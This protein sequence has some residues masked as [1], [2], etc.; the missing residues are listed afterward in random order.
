[1]QHHQKSIPL[2]QDEPLSRLDW[3]Y[4]RWGGVSAVVLTKLW[5]RIHRRPSYKIELDRPVDPA[6]PT[7]FA[8]NHQVS[9][10]PPAIFSAFSFRDLVR[11]SPVKFMTYHKYYNS[12]FKF[13]LYTTGCYPSHG[14]GLTGVKGAVYFARHGYCSFIF[15]EGKRMRNGERGKA[16]EGISRIL[17]EIPEA[18][19][20]LVRINWEPRRRFLSRPGIQVTIS[21]APKNLNRNDPDA[22]MD[23]IYKLK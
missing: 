16:Y 6:H 21:D 9:L 19:L 20:L 17:E 13:P 2:I 23:E 10:D 8:S 15:P 18:R 3:H 4:V 22:I 12:R 14:D 7:V 11:C 5:L 1:V